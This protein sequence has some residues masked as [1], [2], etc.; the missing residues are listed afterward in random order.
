[1]AEKGKS[2]PARAIFHVTF[3]TL[4]IVVGQILP[5]DEATKIDVARKVCYWAIGLDI[6]FRLPLYHLFIRGKD[7]EEGSLMVR[8]ARKTC[9]FLEKWLLIKTKIIREGERHLPTSVVPFATGVLIVIELGLPTY[10]IIPGIVILGF[11][12]PTAREVGIPYGASKVWRGGVKSWQGFIAFVLVSYAVSLVSLY[13][14][15][16]GFPVYPE[17]SAGLIDVT[18]IFAALAGGVAELAEEW[19]HLRIPN[20]LFQS[21]VDDNLLIPVTASLTVAGIMA[22]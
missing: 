7:P 3:G 17:G 9:L 1:M 22:I 14:D 13:L 19:I 12:D 5:I 21:L 16:S 18:I 2:Q 11:G 20:K 10:A 8:V 6:F 4:A 15:R